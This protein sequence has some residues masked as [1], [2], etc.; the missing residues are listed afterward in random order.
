LPP[1][2]FL[3]RSIEEITA[4]LARAGYITLNQRMDVRLA[5]TFAIH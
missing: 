4:E 3:L 1:R 2:A 5:S